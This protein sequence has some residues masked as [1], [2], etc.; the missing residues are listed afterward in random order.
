V[1]ANGGLLYVATISSTVVVS[2]R[3]FRRL[4]GIRADDPGNPL[5]IDV[6]PE[7]LALVVN[8]QGD[9][10]TPEPGTLT[11][12]RGTRHVRAVGPLGYFAGDV[13]ITPDGTSTW[14]TN[15]GLGHGGYVLTF[16]TPSAR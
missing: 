3:T 14:V 9:A 15:F 1:N 8:G 12:I 6:S 11:V 2:T 4:A 7:G 5:G 16:P 13:A 10:P